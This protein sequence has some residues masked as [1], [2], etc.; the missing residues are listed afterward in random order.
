MHLHVACHPI[1]LARRGVRCSIRGFPSQRARV[2]VNPADCAITPS[3]QRNHPRRIAISV[4][5]YST[6]NGLLRKRSG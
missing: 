4:N 1:A 6:R 2:V 3:P 5:A